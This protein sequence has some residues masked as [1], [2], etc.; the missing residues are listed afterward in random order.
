M[1]TKIKLVFKNAKI[2]GTTTSKFV[3]KNKLIDKK[4][5]AFISVIKFENTIIKSNIYNLENKNSFEVGKRVGENFVKENTKSIFSYLT[6]NFDNEEKFLEGLSLVKE[7]IPILGGKLIPVEK[8]KN[9]LVFDNNNIFEKGMVL[10]SLNSKDLNVHL[11]KNL[12]WKALGKNM[13]VTKAKDNILYELDYTPIEN[14]YQKYLGMKF[15]PK[16]KEKIKKFPLLINDNEKGFVSRGILDYDFENKKLILANKIKEGQ[17]VKIAFA[18]EKIISKKKNETK[19]NIIKENISF[20]FGFYSNLEK[21][22]LKKN[23]KKDL[24]SISLFTSDSFSIQNNKMDNLKNTIFLAN[25]NKKKILKENKKKN[26]EVNKKDIEILSNFTDKISKELEK[27]NEQLKL[28][29]KE[30]S[31][32]H[33]LE[34][35]CNTM[36]SLINQELNNDKGVVLIFDNNEQKGYNIEA[37]QN[38]KIDALK[39][40]NEYAS[41]KFLK[42]LIQENKVKIYSELKEK[43]NIN[44][45]FL[46]K[47]G[48]ESIMAIPI[49][50]KKGIKGIV[51]LFNENKNF[52]KKEDINKV[53]IF[54]QHLFFVLEKAKLF[55]NMEKNVA[56]LDTLKTT[57]QLI[58]S[59]LDL[60]EIFKLTVDVIMGTMGVNVVELFLLNDNCLE[61]KASTGMNNKNK[62]KI[63]LYSEEKS[64]DLIQNDKNIIVEE[65]IKEKDNEKTKN[66]NLKSQVYIPLKVR[67]ETIGVL[68]AKQLDHVRKFDKVDK[69][70]LKTLSNQIAIA[71]ENAKIYQEVKD[72]SVKDGLTQLYNH[73]YFQRK[74]KDEIKR[75]KRYKNKLSMLIMD[76]DDF[77]H[78]NDTYGH[79]TGD[80]VLKVLSKTLKEQT[81][82]VDTVARYGGEEF[83]IILPETDYEGLKIVADRLNEVIR[84]DISIKYKTKTLGITVSI[85]G[86]TFNPEDSQKE[87]IKKSDMAL[88]E[89]KDRGK[90]CN[91]IY[92]S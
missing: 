67:D 62:E 38:I 42:K 17:K 56:S 21:N 4:D 77:K 40:F 86:T 78:F 45:S 30:I 9:N 2:I 18:N 12:N 44:L 35:T 72:L 88:Y 11:S 71:I 76:I 16:N 39:K 23:L 24:S 82:N 22:F 52:F 75:S 13:K 19:E 37:S 34:S 8:N 90:D 29:N 6:Q 36:L 92:Q 10:A 68:S 1:L 73:S 50:E 33:D 64:W 48:F 91:V 53:K 84:E 58:N 87:F 59:T 66:F 27:N 79:Q 15:N 51:I 89:A 83:V 74:L 60:E 69:K 3:F 25:E 70:F 5:K 28:I 20:G 46:C 43:C 47:I 49:N 81:R 85:G 7:K 54:H 26:K 31:L 63:I 80:E 32:K 65:N 57:S 41:K 14:I 61:L 55:E